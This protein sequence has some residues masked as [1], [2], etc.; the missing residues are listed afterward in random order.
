[1]NLDRSAQVKLELFSLA[2]EGIYQAAIAGNPGLNVIEWK[3]V[4]Q[5]GSTV[6]SGLY[7]YR[8][9]TEDGVSTRSQAGKVA[10]LH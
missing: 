10:V 9:E 2:G 3:L 5:S 1:M 7:L 4:N 6:A 8:L